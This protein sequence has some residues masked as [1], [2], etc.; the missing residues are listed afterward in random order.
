MSQEL[1]LLISGVVLVVLDCVLNTGI[2]TTVGIVCA[3][4]GAYLI[5]TE[6]LVAALPPGVFVLLMQVAAVLRRTEESD[7]VLLKSVRELK[8]DE[9]IVIRKDPL[10]VKVRG[11]P[12]RAVSKTKLRQGERVVVLDVKGNKLVVKPKKIGER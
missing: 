4:V 2:V 1:C 8:G 11:E 9:G 7:N 3:W 5:G 10:L 6:Y 12:W